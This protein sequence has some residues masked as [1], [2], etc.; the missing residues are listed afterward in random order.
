ME[1]AAAR[2]PIRAAGLAEPHHDGSELYVDRLGD[3]AEVRLR[4]P[5]GSAAAVYLRY[6]KDGEPRIVE[7]TPGSEDDGDVWWSAELP[8]RNPTVPYRWLLIGGGVGY[9]WL[10]GT[11]AYPYEVTPGDD[12]RLNAEPAGAEWHLSSVGY[13]VFLDRFAS[14]GANR[15]L[16]GWALRR[17]WER[18]PDGESRNTNY[19]FYGGDL[20]G[21]EQ[22]LDHI[23]SL[24][25]TALWLTPFFPGASNHRYDPASFDRVDP[26]L[27]GDAALESLLSAVH[28]RRMHVFG[29]LSLDHCSD[30]HPWFLRAAADPSSEERS[31]F[32]FGPSEIHG[33]ATWRGTKGL[34]RFDWR[35][36]ELRARVGA[37]VQ[38]WQ[39]LGIDGWRIGAADMVGRYRDADLTA[40]VERWL[41]DEVDGAPLI[42]EY[43]H[44]FRPDL[45]GRG[46]H[47][48]TNYA[49]FLRPVWW[50]LRGTAVG[51]EAF[52]IFTSANAPLYN[53]RQAA[54]VMRDARAGAPWDSSLHSWLL[55]DSHDTPRF[56]TVSG[57]RER[58]VVGVGLQMTMPGVPMIYAGDELG[59]G[60][61]SGR[62]SRV[63]MPWD[64]PER[65]DEQLLA[66]YRR[67]VALRRS[68]DALARGG[69]RYV[70]VD[71]DVLL[72]LRESKVERVLCLAARASHRPV[73]VPWS[74]LETLY[75]ED[76]RD[77]VLPS[78]GPAFHAWRVG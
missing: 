34:P 46:W 66:E 63:P 6:L 64:E 45:D 21:I 8:L 65:W 61:P 41:R 39:E 27:G 14:S 51:Q 38:G 58:H 16:P 30:A 59:L 54:T 3:S 5:P 74:E 22:R 53:G 42:G 75:G 78:G 10:N 32:M 7:A 56:C 67:L 52:D 25:A 60:A 73:A 11:G 24:G 1:S 37:S 44:D 19:E 68:S 40:E 69:L 17:E 15:S 71:D 43:W 55:L 31:F 35:S 20:A 4:T 48:V 57:S 70:H 12:F 72:Y 9:R 33:H 23:E 29:D 2:G 50:W 62:S 47:G 26:L 76:A 49:G 77:G 36:A 13:E 28:A 18:L